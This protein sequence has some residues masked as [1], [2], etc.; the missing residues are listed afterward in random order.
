LFFIVFGDDGSKMVAALPN[1]NARHT[2]ILPELRLL[3]LSADLAL[4]NGLRVKMGSRQK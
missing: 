1:A 2:G 3:F 4:K